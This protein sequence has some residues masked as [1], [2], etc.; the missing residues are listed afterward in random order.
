MVLAS[1][2]DLLILYQAANLYPCIKLKTAA[3]EK[4]GIV[5]Y[6]RMSSAH[7]A[8][9]P[10]LCVVMLGSRELIFFLILNITFILTLPL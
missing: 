4:L 1:V 5:I 6:S 3:R 8:V 2:L 9:L 10:N 7:G